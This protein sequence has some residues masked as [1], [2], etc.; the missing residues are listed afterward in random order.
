MEL[1]C[2]L[3]TF[4]TINPK[5]RRKESNKRS[6]P[7]ATVAEETPSFAATAEEVD[8]PYELTDILIGDGTN[9]AYADDWLINRKP[10]R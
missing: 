2:L 9:I 5:N 4:G 1:A 10:P 6:T 8:E 7:C 3:S